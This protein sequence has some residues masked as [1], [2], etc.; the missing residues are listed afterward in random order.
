VYDDC[1]EKKGTVEASLI[2]DEIQRGKSVM[3]DCVVVTGDLGPLLSA[4]VQVPEFVV[5]LDRPID[6]HVVGSPINIMN[7]IIQGKVT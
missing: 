2:L 1:P 7:S 3:Y 6:L 5:G 4:W